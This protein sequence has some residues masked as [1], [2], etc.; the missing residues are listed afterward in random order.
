MKKKTVVTLLIVAALPVTYFG[1]RQYQVHQAAENL[2][3]T[4]ERLKA[5]DNAVAA[6]VNSMD[7]ADMDAAKKLCEAV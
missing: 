4:E 3:K 7:P 6:S 5:C 2:R 1:Y